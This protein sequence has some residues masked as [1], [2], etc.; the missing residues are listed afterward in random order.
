MMLD[1]WSTATEQ[2]CREQRSFLSG[3]QQ[4][5]F[6]MRRRLQK[7]KLQLLVRVRASQG[8]TVTLPRSSTSGALRT[9]SQKA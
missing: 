1:R 4:L 9:V 6:F 2:E 7:M 5:E 8:D 3:R